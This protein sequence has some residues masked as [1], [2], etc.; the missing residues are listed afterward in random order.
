MFSTRTVLFA[1]V[2]TAA[3]TL[4]AKPALADATVKVPFSFTVE[5]KQC[6]AGRYVIKGDASTNTVTLI[7]RHSAKVFTWIVVPNGLEG[8]PRS[9][10]LRFE[11]SGPQ[12]VL[13]S[14]RYG[15]QSTARLDKHNTSDDEMESERG[16]R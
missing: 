6:P 1:L 15:A 4:A 8:N 5:G 2:A 10:V 11:Q 13:Q 16:G 12:H 3:A 7:S 14:I 9:V